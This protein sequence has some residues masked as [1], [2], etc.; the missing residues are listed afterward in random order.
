MLLRSQCFAKAFF[1]LADM[2]PTLPA[3]LWPGRLRSVNRAIS[4]SGVIPEAPLAPI[5]L[6]FETTGGAASELGFLRRFCPAVMDRVFKSKMK[7]TP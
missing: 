3:E 2:F 5:R 6:P 4:A 1:V 7:C